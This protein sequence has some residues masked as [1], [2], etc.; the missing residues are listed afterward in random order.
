MNRTFLDIETFLVRFRG[1]FQEKGVEN[2]KFIDF[3]EK[4]N[5]F[6]KDDEEQKPSDENI[7][8]K[9][10]TAGVSLAS[11]ED[12]SVELTEGAEKIKQEIER[13]EFRKKSVLSVFSHEIHQLEQEK[14]S[15][16]LIIGQHTYD[17]YIKENGEILC[18]DQLDKV[19][20]LEEQIQQK[21][22][23]IEA[24]AVRYDE[25]IG[26][27]E[28]SMTLHQKEPE[29]LMLPKTASK[30]LVI[31]PHC[32]EMIEKNRF[33]FSCGGALEGETGG[34][35]SEIQHKE[36][37]IPENKE[38]DS[39]KVQEVEQPNQVPEQVAEKSMPSSGKFNATFGIQVEKPPEVPKTLQANGG[40]MTENI[41]ENVF[42]DF[43]KSTLG[44]T[45]DTKSGLSPPTS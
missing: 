12:Q 21:N 13:V 38:N 40:S 41:T 15:N 20:N 25:E 45:E 35:T 29:I 22:T 34:N 33:C 9:S 18:Q 6:S 28:A 42:L 27:L 4:I 3:L 8:N 44:I 37:H 39:V 17:S 19:K 24:F 11:T 36:E 23:Q 1:K 30:P 16:L 31:C 10:Q 43:N 32:N 7:E 5:P 26:I 14:T 2:M